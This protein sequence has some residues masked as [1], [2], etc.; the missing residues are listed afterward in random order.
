MKTQTSK[1]SRPSLKGKRFSN[2]SKPLRF[3]PGA[4][5][6]VLLLAASALGQSLPSS[7]DAS[8]KDLVRTVIA[9]ELRSQTNESHWMY[10]V[11]REEQGKKTEKQ[12]IQTAQGPIDRLMSVDAH[13]LTA[14]QEQE[15]TNRIQH[16]INDSAEQRKN[17]QARKREAEQCKEVF[18]M[19]PEAFIFHYAGTENNLL[20]LA[21]QP[22][23][24]FQSE[25]RAAK[26]FHNLQ[27]E[28]WVEPTQRRLVR[29]SGQLVA[30]VKFA[31]GLLGY[32]QKGGHFDVQQKELTHGE[33]E[34]TS[35]VVDMQGKALLFKSISVQQKERRTNFQTVPGTLTYAEAADM[36]NKQI[37]LASNNN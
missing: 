26:V 9:N 16:L 1:L 31:G 13:P 35:L 36:L 17:E 25:S 37:I 32:L 18:K 30:D 6:C 34:I 24:D 21:Y 15:E 12:V 29:M 7:G 8:A 3:L 10:R 2:P 14:S 4:C 23:P 5:S 33:W 11:E 20:K 19:I 27:G 22:N 28:M